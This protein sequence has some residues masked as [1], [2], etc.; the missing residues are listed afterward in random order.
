MPTTANTRTAPVAKHLHAP[1]T[2]AHMLAQSVQLAPDRTAVV[3]AGRELSYL[4]LGQRV[5]D[6]ARE[7]KQRVPRGGI[8]AAPLSNSAE[9]VITSFAA[10]TAGLRYAP[11]NPFYGRRELATLFAAQAPD[12]IVHNADSTAAATA[13]GEDTGSPLLLLDSQAALADPSQDPA[14]ELLHVTPDLG[15]EDPALLIFTG[16]TTGLSKAV[17]HSHAGMVFSIRAHCTGWELR[18]DV[19]RVLG[20]APL[21]HIWGLG[22]AMLAPLFLR[23][24]L[25]LIPRYQPELVLQELAAQKATVFAGG[26]A[27][28]YAGLMA[29][30]QFGQHDLG[31]LTLALTGGSPCPQPLREAWSQKVGCPLL[32]GWG[33]SEGA[34]LVFNWRAHAQRPSSVGHPAPGIELKLVDIA[35]PSRVVAPGESGEVCVRGPQVMRGYRLQA[36]GAESGLDPEGWLHSGDIGYQ[37]EDGYLYLVDRKK[38]MIL[39]GGYNVYPRQVE[40]H[41]RSHPDVRDVAV[42]GIKDEFLGECPYAFIVLHAGHSLATEDFLAWCQ[43]TLVKYKRPVGVQILADLPRTGANKLDKRRLRELLKDDKQA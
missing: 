31:N 29:S 25:I 15:G 40:D 19:E 17:E 1:E 24:T 3:V 13:L 22:F 38:E 39:V 10:F 14:A 28:I 32:E 35:D 7:L 4:E 16:G 30:P 34:P 8:I 6:L 20:V 43:E 2:L 21:F 23:S 26:P 18:Y 12:L 42:V 11:L 41:I 36:E 27:P 33:M 5:L 37:D 9:C